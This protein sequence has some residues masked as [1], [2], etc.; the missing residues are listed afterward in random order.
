MGLQ[1]IASVE[2]SHS[3]TLRR[4]GREVTYALRAAI[5]LFAT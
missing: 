4:M 5:E 2:A 3:E 1:R